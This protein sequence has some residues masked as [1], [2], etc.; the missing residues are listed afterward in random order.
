MKII[1]WNILH[2]GGSRVSDIV[3]HLKSHRPDIVCLQEFRHSKS[4]AQLVEGLNQL[5]LSYSHLPDTKKASTNTVAVFSKY[6][7]EATDHYQDSKG[8]VRCVEVRPDNTDLRI[9]T[10]SFPHKKE[11]IP[12][13]N[14]LLDLDQSYLEIPSIMVGDFNCGIPFEDSETK[15]FYATH[16]FQQLLRQGWVD[17]W[18]T[19]NKE[20]REFTWFST[21]KGNG[22]RYDHALASESFDARITS[23]YYDHAAREHRLSDHSP[24]LVEFSTAIS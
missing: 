12:L 1:S 20:A 15:T 9:I 22:F 17:S 21:Q 24:L 6:A 10:L 5:G 4:K 2:G 13:F 11:Q 16:L 18:R 19:R 8:A 23:V 14:L 7:F 3:A